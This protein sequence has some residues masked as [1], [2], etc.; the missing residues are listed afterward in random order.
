[1]LMQATNRRAEAKERYQKA[2]SIDPSAAVAANNLAWLQAEDGGNLDVALRLAQTAKARLP[3]SPE[4][5]DTLGYIFY[6]KGLYSSAIAALKVSVARDPGN[7]AY[8]FRLGMAYAKN[9]DA[10]LARESLNE[11][12]RINRAFDGADEARAT[13][14]AL[15]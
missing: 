6:L 7:P 13:L 10:T 15:R 5:N 12:L 3:E 8:Q 11:A 2:L 1:M 4:V 14:S 9:G